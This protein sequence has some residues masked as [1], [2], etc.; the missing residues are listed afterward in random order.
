MLTTWLDSRTAGQQHS[1]HLPSQSSS[2]YLIRRVL[3]LE[4][5]RAAAANWASESAVAGFPLRSGCCCRSGA[6]AP[7]AVAV[8]ATQVEGAAA[9]ATE[10]AGE[11]TAGGTAA[12]LCPLA[13]CVRPGSKVPQT[14]MAG[15]A[16]AE[17]ARSHRIDEKGAAVSCTAGGRLSELAEWRGS[18]VWNDPGRVLGAGASGTGGGAGGRRVGR[19]GDCGGMGGGGGGSGSGGALALVT[20]E[21]MADPPPSSA[22][23]IVPPRLLPPPP[24]PLR[25]CAFTAKVRAGAAPC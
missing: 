13:T 10:Q 16:A 11:E 12:G 5:R 4:F 15:L 2:C 24:P 8:R 14:S 22:P 21:V 9:T 18:G 19:L 23:P 17:S 6:P 20:C 1:S 3:G 25:L 7:A